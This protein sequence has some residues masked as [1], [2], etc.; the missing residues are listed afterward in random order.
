MTLPDITL[1]PADPILD[2]ILTPNAAAAYLQ[3]TRPNITKLL[4][5]GYLADLTMS[6]LTPLR[7]AGFVSAGGQLPLIQT[8][9]AEESTDDWRKWWGDAPTL[10]DEDWLNAQ[11]GDWTG[12]GADRIE[13]ASYLLVGLGGVITGVTRVIK[14]VPSG[15]P[16]KARFELELLGRLTGE[17]KSFEKSFPERPSDEEQLFAHSLVGKRY[18]PRAGGSVM[19]L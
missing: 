4:A 17:L 6:S 14:A 11:R 12:A 8:A 5:S 19:W 16:R 7:T 9:P 18:E 2:E 10:S 1:T 15:S 3:S 13:R